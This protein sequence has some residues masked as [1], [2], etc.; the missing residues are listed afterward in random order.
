MSIGLAMIAGPLT[1]PQLQKLKVT[2]PL[3]ASMACLLISVALG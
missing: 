1:G 2:Y 3:Y